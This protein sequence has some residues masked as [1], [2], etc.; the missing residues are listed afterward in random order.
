MN[1][2]NAKFLY[3]QL[4]NLGLKN[5]PD[6]DTAYLY[7]CFIW[8]LINEDSKYLERN[9]ITGASVERASNSFIKRDSVGRIF[10]AF[11]DRI[12]KKK[13][14]KGKGGGLKD[15]LRKYYVKEIFD[16]LL[17][18]G[19]EKVTLEQLRDPN[20]LNTLSFIGKGGLTYTFLS[21]TQQYK[22]IIKPVFPSDSNHIYYLD[23]LWRERYDCDYQI[24]H[25]FIRALIDEADPKVSN[26]G[27]DKP[28]FVIRDSVNEE[29]Y[30]KRT[31]AL[32][33]RITPNVSKFMNMEDFPSTIILSRLVC[34]VSNPELDWRY[35]YYS[36]ADLLELYNKGLIKKSELGAKRKPKIYKNF[37]AHHKCFNPNCCNP[38][39]IQPLIEAE[40]NE[41][42]KALKDNHIVTRPNEDRQIA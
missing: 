23:K 32:L 36:E 20:I 22:D 1:T 6:R 33:E 10:G 40:H 28:C 7:L 35:H 17:T 15:N 14:S 42:H 41:L 37:V 13:T 30:A 8:N 16:L 31:R 18:W 4:P 26:Q 19:V 39:H 24:P 9:W 27:E 5:M 12:K 25:S 11:K 29:G 3:L 38:D 34:M 21:K 2:E